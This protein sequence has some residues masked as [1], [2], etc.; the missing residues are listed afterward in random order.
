MV[1]R[2]I[3]SSSGV[4]VSK[5]M[6]TTA[7]PIAPASWVLARRALALWPRLDSRALRRCHEDPR[8]L[9]LLISRRTSLSVETIMGMLV[10]AQVSVEEGETWFG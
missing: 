3:G 5:R 4:E 2:S 9:A 10:G 6:L 7:E 8:R 1:E